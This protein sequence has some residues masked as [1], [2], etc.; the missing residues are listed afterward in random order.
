LTYL[1][2]AELSFKAG[3]YQGALKNYAAAR[4]YSSSPQ[5]HLDLGLGILDVRRSSRFNGHHI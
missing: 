2:L 5:H 3:S 1:A 4:E